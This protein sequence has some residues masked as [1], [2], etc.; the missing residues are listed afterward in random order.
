MDDRELPF[1]EHLEELRQRLK[2]SL[3][4]V[5]GLFL[6]TFLLRE[7]IFSLVQQP[8]VRAVELFLRYHPG[9]KFAAGLHFKDPIEPF[10][11]YMKV[12]F[13]AAL[14]LA[15]PFLLYQIWKFVAPGLYKHEKV[16]TFPFLVA[17]TVMFALG[18]TFCHQLA[19]PFGY[20]ALLTYAGND[21]VPMMMMT[22]YTSTTLTLLLAFGVIFETPV[23]L[24]FL[25]RLGVLTP[26]QLRRARRYAAVIIAIV[27]AF[28]TPP[29]VV[30]QILLGIPLYLLYE[31]SIIGARFLGKPVPREPPAASDPGLAG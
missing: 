23:V 20:Y 18:A 14:F 6:G 10:F 5:F 1:T 25:C 28:L 8:M 2:R 7:Q 21:L 22:E 19:L 4:V 29:D 15:V 26:E 9:S 12:S 24:I 27:A 16:A 30:S 11:T 13:F 3:I 31:V 17:S